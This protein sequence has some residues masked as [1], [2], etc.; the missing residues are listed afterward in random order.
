MSSDKIKV[1]VVDDEPIARDIL[2]AYLARVERFELL[3]TCASAMEAFKLL[4]QVK[5]DLLLLDINMPEVSGLDLLRN[6]KNPPCV[7]LTTASPDFAMQGYEL[8][9]LDYLLKPIAFDRFAKALAKVEKHVLGNQ[10]AAVSAPAQAEEE[11][12]MVVRAE[13]KW[14]KVNIRQLW[15]VEGLKDYIKLHTST[16]KVVIRSTMKNFEE[17]LSPYPEFIR[18]HKS[19]IVNAAFVTEFDTN[20]VKVN[21]QL[22]SVGNTYRNEVSKLMRGKN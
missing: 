7:V 15:L 10:A 9:V 16:G 20:F 12:L 19:F 22:V 2:A 1:L 21:E 14:V 13:G 11:H 3:G 8:D 17:Q 6:L 4:S 18:V 5:T